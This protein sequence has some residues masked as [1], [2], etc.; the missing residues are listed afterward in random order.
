MEGIKQGDSQ[1]DPD[2]IE[3]DPD[4][5]NGL[6]FCWAVPVKLKYSSESSA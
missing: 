3:L 5:E 6:R 2:M 4:V 1:A